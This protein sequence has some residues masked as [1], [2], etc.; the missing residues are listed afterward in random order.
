MPDLKVNYCIVVDA[1]TICEDSMVP[2]VHRVGT[3]TAAAVEAVGQDGL[4]AAPSQ[5]SAHIV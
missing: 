1:D 4:R 3:L 2:L 5:V